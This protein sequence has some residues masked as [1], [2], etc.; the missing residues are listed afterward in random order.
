MTVVPIY[1]VKAK[2]A[3]IAFDAQHRLVLADIEFV[4]VGDAAVILEGLGA[5]GFLIEAGHRNLADFE[6]FRR[7][8]EDHV[9]RIVVNRIDD[10]AFIENDGLHVTPL[11]LDAARESGRTSADYDDVDILRDDFPRLTHSF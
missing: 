9:G 11:Q 4:V 10:A 7:G 3:V 1:R 5:S 8:E 2:I 6:Q